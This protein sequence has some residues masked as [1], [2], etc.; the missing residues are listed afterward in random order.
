VRWFENTSGLETPGI[1][2]PAFATVAHQFG[3]Q[4]KIV[5]VAGARS[6]CRTRKDLISQLG[7]HRF[8]QNI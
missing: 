7:K 4:E 2:S 8:D 6:V 3:K 1:K 5:S